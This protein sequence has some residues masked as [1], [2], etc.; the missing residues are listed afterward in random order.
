MRKNIKVTEKFVKLTTEI[1]L[2]IKRN[3]SHYQRV[4]DE[5]ADFIQKKLS[6]Y[7]LSL[8]NKIK[9]EKFQYNS[10]K[11]FVSWKGGGER[12]I[13]RLAKERTCSKDLFHVI[14]YYLFEF[15]WDNTNQ[16]SFIDTTE[17]M[18]KKKHIVYFD[19]ENKEDWVINFGVSIGFYSQLTDSLKFDLYQDD[20]LKRLIGEIQISLIGIDNSLFDFY[21][22]KEGENYQLQKSKKYFACPRVTNFKPIFLGFQ[23]KKE[24]CN[25]LEEVINEV[26]IPRIKIVESQHT[27]FFLKWSDIRKKYFLWEKGRPIFITMISYWDKEHLISFLRKYLEHIY[28]W[29]HLVELKNTN[30]LIEGSDIEIA[31]ISEQ[32]SYNNADN[33]QMRLISPI[34]ANK[35]NEKIPYNV[36]A[37]NKSNSTYFCSCLIITENYGVFVSKHNLRLEPHK[38]LE[39]IHRRY[40]AFELSNDDE[41]SAV[42]YIK[43]IISKETARTISTLKLDELPIKSELKII[44]QK[45]V[46]SRGSKVEGD[47]TTKTIEVK[48]VRGT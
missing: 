46:T 17:E 47:W 9:S 43:I 36:I 5:L 29:K 44:E 18:P 6:K 20:H 42:N 33:K 21:P 35:E 27:Q 8:Y 11:V 41:K 16:Q 34:K 10:N 26:P 12:T 7:N 30:T 2:N 15:K 3:G 39:L 45:G 13:K 28:H 14:G 23:G 38:E 24:D 22:A 25:L 32:I 31:F 4:S 40:A 37:K 1:A 48:I 19:D